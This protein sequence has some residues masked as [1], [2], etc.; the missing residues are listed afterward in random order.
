MAS[1]SKNTPAPKPAV[2]MPAAQVPAIFRE[3]IAF[4]QR[5]QLDQAKARYEYI[6]KAQ[7]GHYPSLHLLGVVAAQ[8]RNFQAAADLIGKA[9]AIFPN[10]PNFHINRGNALKEL[11]QL[12]EAVAS[13][14]KA[15]ALK[16]DNAQAHS[17]RGVA[18][19]TLKRFEAAVASYDKAIALQPDYV[20]A[21]SNRGSAL[22]ELH[23]L[24]A[25]IA[26]CDN[27]IAIN[28]GYAEAHFN[29]GMA[30]HA[31]GQP[32]A[33]IASYDKAIAIRPSLAD[34]SYCRGIALQELGQLDA[35]IASYEQAIA[36]KPDHA[37]ACYNR[38][39][40]LVDLQRYAP[41]I[42]SYDQAIAIHADF[43]QAHSN[44][45]V[46]LQALKQWDAAVAS[47]DR[48][49]AIAPDYAEAHINRGVALHA[50][51]R[52]DE[53]VASYDQALVF[54]PDSVKAHTNRG[55][56]L[57]AMK[58]LDEAVASYD[59]AI[60]I[61][62]DYA[63]PRF[64]KSLVLLLTGDFPSGWDLYQWLWKTEKAV[65]KLRHFTQPAWSGE[66][67]LIGKTILV[68]SE[69]GLGDM[70]QFCRYA[71]QLADLGARVVLEVPEPLLGLL[72]GLEGLSALVAKGSTLPAFDYHCL[73]L[74]LPRLFKTDLAAIP[75]RQPY[76]YS[77][78]A[79]VSEWANRLGTKTKP[80]V[81]LVWSGSVEHA[82]DYNRSIALS[83]LA[84]HLPDAF[85]YVSLQKEVRDADAPA[86]GMNGSI[87]H[88]GDEIKDFGDTAALCELM[89]VVISV[90]TSVAHL[91]GAL[92][93]P[94]WVLLP[95][96]P[97]W[98]W[99]LDR[100]DNPWYASVKLYRQH[101]DGEWSAVFD[102][103]RADLLSRL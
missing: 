23:Q 45:G 54:Q 22:R 4:H 29:R 69:Q 8:T 39:V 83:E 77:D 92:G 1:I 96:V 40:A 16:P 74:A 103:V 30:L 76:L 81:G 73:L 13:Y 100:D 52:L 18:L 97:D 72:S 20:E 15:I 9:I 75:G 7:P 67:P 32:L 36:L 93:K 27:A 34:A 64:Y 46:A 31:L 37:Q 51:K 35:A 38:G 86:L 84:A 59:R 48:A 47:F 44:R 50:L 82:I 95:V 66:E 70:I 11:Q 56:A 62:P 55:V 102:R 80:R 91:G 49:I 94:T 6:L 57:H 99:L 24:D 5:G 101:S 58:R 78:P 60:A 88:F 89:D 10:D 14:D 21:H 42:A 12:E 61:Q 68:H 65:P 25:S 98:R 43:A 2:A 3:A 33:A 28:P 53:A 17:N 19:Q 90:D 87:R 63:E 71:K 26:S 41:A 79:K 85:E